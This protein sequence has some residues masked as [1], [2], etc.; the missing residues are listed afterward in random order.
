MRTRRLQPLLEMISDAHRERGAVRI[1]D[2]GGTARYWQLVP[3]GFLEEH[4]VSVT[5]VNIPGSGLPADQDL[6]RFI[7]G[8]GCDL[9]MI[10]D[11]AFDIAHSNS[12]I[13]H[14]GDWERMKAFAAETHR[15]ARKYFVQTPN[16][17]FPLE[18]HCM[19]FF[20]HWIPRPARIWLVRHF[21]LGHWPRATSV[22]EAMQ[23]IDSARLLTKNMLRSLFPS[24]R[25]RCERLFLLPKSY[26]A[27][28]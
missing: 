17:W 26:T 27:I 3:A 8:D 11:Q 22:D 15:V 5:I 20:I 2:I 24:S 4:K 9:A 13:E 6:Y 1:I 10:E 21:R 16:Y 25:I 18:P 7:E 14:V 19:T 23:R 28:R 12:V